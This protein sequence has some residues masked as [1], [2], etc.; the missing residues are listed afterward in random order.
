MAN[1]CES[2][3]TWQ[4]RLRLDQRMV[5]FEAGQF[6]MLRLHDTV[7]EV[8]L[9]RP[10]SPFDVRLRG[11]FTYIDILYKVVGKGTHVMTGLQPGHR[12]DLVG[13]LGHGFQ[14]LEA[15]GHL[16]IGGGIGVAPL[17]LLA[18]TLLQSGVLKKEIFVYLGAQN[19]QDILGVR[20]FRKLGLVPVLVTEDGSAGI[21]GR[22]TA[23]VRERLADSREKPALYACGPTPMLKA[24]V[25]LAEAHDLLCRLSLEERMACGT[26]VCFSCVAGVMESEGTWS[27]KRTCMEGP[28]VDGRQLVWDPKP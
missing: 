20:E 18:R 8:F 25:G 14:V 12:I 5:H 6:V 11:R 23:P 24:V 17:H 26:G 19:K 28:V 10:F 9:N 4:M 15:S 2:G 1:Q 22:V 16:L 13:M 3:C 21:K 27:F 7:G